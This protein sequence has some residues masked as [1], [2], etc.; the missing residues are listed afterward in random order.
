[1]SEFSHIEDDRARMVDI[2]DK[3]AVDREATALG[4]IRLSPS[5]V[6]AIAAGDIE[7]G[8]VL[9]V[10]RVAG[11][12]AAKR[13]AETVPMCHQVPLS[14]VTVDFGLNEAAITAKATVSTTARTGVEMEAINAVTG[15]LICI[16]D[17]VKSAEKDDDGQYPTMAL[18]D[19][20]VVEKRKGE[21]A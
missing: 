12:Q 18:D 19:I 1:M 7:K 16:W 6:E 2:G 15:A 13:T 9:S 20:H 14:G 5:T 21:S 4:T 3:P 10:A 11:I 8:A 17:M